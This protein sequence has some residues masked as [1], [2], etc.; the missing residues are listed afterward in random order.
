ME[1]QSRD[2]LEKLLSTFKVE[3]EEHIQAMS[4][5][6][7]ELEK[8]ADA[9]K[10][11]EIIERVFREAH[12]LKGAARAVNSVEIE[13]ICQSLENIFS[14]LKN[15]EIAVSPALFDSLH[16]VPVGPV[17]R[18]SDARGSGRTVVCPFTQSVKEGFPASPFSLRL[19]VFAVHSNLETAID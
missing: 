12:S 11:A 14:A 16:S 3:A 6:L 8:A 1:R 4:S 18:S 15:K 2:F 19:C 9:G 13:A 17:S 5:G 7:I 10:R